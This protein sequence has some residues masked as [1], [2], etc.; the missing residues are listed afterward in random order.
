[1]ISFM[2]DQSL[3]KIKFIYLIIPFMLVSCAGDES[4]E[5]S[6]VEVMIPSEDKIPHYNRD[7]S[8][9][10]TDQT[11]N[12]DNAPQELILLNQY[13]ED[14]SYLNQERLTVMIDEPPLG[15]GFQ[16]AN[17]DENRFII[18]DFSRSQ[19]IEYNFSNHRSSIIADI[20]RGPGDLHFPVGLDVQDSIVYVGRQDGFISIFDCQIIPCAFKEAISLDFTPVSVSKADN[21]YAVLGNVTD[22]ESGSDDQS[23][24][25]KPVRIINEE[26]TVIDGFGDSYDFSE[27]AFLLTHPDFSNG[28]IQ[29]SRSELT[30]IF[31]YS[32]FPIIYA[33]DANSLRIKDTYKLSDFDL[34]KQ[35]Y[36]PDTRRLYTPEDA[37]SYIRNLKILDQSMLLI[38]TLTF[39]NRERGPMGFIFDYSYDYYAVDLSNSNACYIGGYDGKSQENIGKNINLLPTG[40]IVYSY[41]DG[42]LYSYK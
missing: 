39:E 37:V 21:L 2:Y 15:S 41:D 13:L 6:S 24:S 17:I 14:S 3:K 32:R 22:T 4:D 30:Y 26:G 16:M 42:L 31:S 33:Y 40:L 23:D 11:C 9:I 1:M 38:E 34:G 25:I 20:G 27:H 29:Y 10:R 5:F 28:N 19:L 36:L 12:F 7:H 35:R 18:L 8:Y